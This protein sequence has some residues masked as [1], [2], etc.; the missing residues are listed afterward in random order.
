MIAKKAGVSK[1]SVSRCLRGHPN[2]SLK[3]QERVRKIAYDMGYRPNPMISALM[4][5]IRSRK[6]QDY[7]T[8][9][10][11]LDD[12]EG[13]RPPMFQ[14]SWNE[15]LEGIRSQAE[16]LG[17]KLDIFRYKE[18]HW[19]EKRLSRIL[20]T[21]NIRGLIIPH[22]FQ[23]IHL[24]DL[25]L[26]P[27]ACVALGYTLLEPQL[28]K[29][30]PDF[31]HG[32][33]IALR[34]LRSLNYRRPAFLTLRNNLERT[35]NLYLSAFLADQFLHGQTPRVLVAD[36]ES[37]S[38]PD[39]LDA[40]IREDRPDCIIST[41]QEAAGII[42]GRGHRIPQDIGFVQLNWTPF[43]K[44]CAGVK[45]RNRLQGVQAV[46]LVNASILANEY[47]IPE[48]PVVHLVANQWVP[49]DSVRQQS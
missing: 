19:N 18:E 3:T 25:D 39:L 47:G 23:F 6:K 9:L 44:G 2:N 31:S 38:D 49:G 34:K 46:N 4:S 35:K 15:H 42:N 43:W 7:S 29:V 33:D 11:V 26:F 14:T 24:K 30:C 10:A 27:F 41:Y 28:H 17:Y 32:M 1:M 22:Q 21:R 5:D 8:V 40:W 37:A 20:W 16:H 12:F 36:R 13:K 48:E 45:N